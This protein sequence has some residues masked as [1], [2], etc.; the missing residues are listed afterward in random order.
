MPHIGTTSPNQSPDLSSL[1]YV[2]LPQARVH[3]SHT[4]LPTCLTTHSQ[5]TETGFSPSRTQGMFHFIISMIFTWPFLSQVPQHRMEAPV[6]L[7][8]LCWFI[9][10]AFPWQGSKDKG[11]E[12]LLPLLLPLL[13]L[14]HAC[15]TF[16][17]GPCSSSSSSPSAHETLQGTVTTG[18]LFKS[19]TRAL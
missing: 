16:T 2:L 6:S 7:W 18:S 14:P 1:P 12:L 8:A 19:C 3:P 17:S 10:V 11:W 13:P 5:P 15:L 4:E 9:L